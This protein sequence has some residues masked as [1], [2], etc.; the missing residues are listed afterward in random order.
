[1]IH[2]CV[3]CENGNHNSLSDLIQLIGWSI[4]PQDLL[5]R[6]EPNVY[7]LFHIRCQ[8]INCGYSLSVYYTQVQYI[9]ASVSSKYHFDK[10]TGYKTENKLT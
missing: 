1:M 7:N 9:V 8:L 6:C 3:Y 4:E 5:F 2:G 10:K